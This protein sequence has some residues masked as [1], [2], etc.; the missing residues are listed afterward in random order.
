MKT[1]FDH[2]REHLWLKCQ[3]H[4][5]LANATC[6]QYETELINQDLAKFDDPLDM[7]LHDMTSSERVRLEQ[8][9][10]DLLISGVRI[11]ADDDFLQS[12]L[13]LPQPLTEE[14]LKAFE[15]ENI[16]LNTTATKLQ[17]PHIPG[18]PDTGSNFIA[19]DFRRVA[20]QQMEANNARQ[21]QSSRNIPQPP[22]STEDGNAVRQSITLRS[23]INA[24]KLQ[25]RGRGRPSKKD[26][27]ASVQAEIDALMAL[28]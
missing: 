27:W 25:K 22:A 28:S 11:H 24:T 9:F 14:E 4:D 17:L 1:I 23:G 21:L 8:K 2:I 5:S 18:L 10:D 7:A 3:G 15:N 6:L 19:E 20:K 12:M 13:G 26:K 16:P